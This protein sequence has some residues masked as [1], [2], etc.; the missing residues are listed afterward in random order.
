RHYD[1]R[2]L[3]LLRNVDRG[4][5]ASAAPR[6]RRSVGIRNLSQLG[7]V[8][9]GQSSRSLQSRILRSWWKTLGFGAQAGLVE[10]SATNMGWKRCPGFKPRFQPKGSLGAVN[11]ESGGSGTFVC[12]DRSPSRWAIS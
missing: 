2:Q 9:A 1:V 12:S 4:R 3:D 8:L 5:V 7:V 11:H 10:R 6:D